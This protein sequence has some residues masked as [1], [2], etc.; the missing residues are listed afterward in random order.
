MGVFFKKV[1]DEFKSTNN[2]Q[3]MDRSR[4]YNPT[5]LEYKNFSLN[6]ITFPLSFEPSIVKFDFINKLSEER[7]ELI[8]SSIDL[9]FQFGCPFSTSVNYENFYSWRDRSFQV[10]L[11]ASEDRELSLH[12]YQDLTFF[13]INFLSNAAKKNTQRLNHYFDHESIECLLM[14]QE[15]IEKF[16][17]TCEEQIVPDK[18]KALLVCTPETKVDEVQNGA[19]KNSAELISL[20]PAGIKTSTFNF[21]ISPRE[22][23]YYWNE[24]AP[25]QFR[26]GRHGGF[27]LQYWMESGRILHS[28]TD[29]ELQ[30]NKIVKRNS[31]HS[32][33]QAQTPFS[34][35]FSKEKN[36]NISPYVKESVKKFQ[37]LESFFQ[38]K[39]PV[40]L[41]EGDELEA[42][43]ISYPI[44]TIQ[45]LKLESFLPLFQVELEKETPSS[46]ASPAKILSELESDSDFESDQSQGISVVTLTPTYHLAPELYIGNDF[47]FNPKSHQ[48]SIHGLYPSLSQINSEA[49]LHN[50]KFYEYQSSHQSL[51]EFYLNN[52]TSHPIETQE[53]GASLLKFLQENELRSFF[54]WSRIKPI[55]LEVEC[56]QL[57]LDH[58][59]YRFC[60]QLHEKLEDSTK[61]NSK[62]HVE[63]FL[64][65]WNEILAGFNEGLNAFLSPEYKNHLGGRSA[66][67][68][69]FILKFLR[70]SGIFI[71][72]FY[73]L[74]Q[75]VHATDKSQNPQ[76]L[77]HAT[78]KE[79]KKYFDE[80]LSEKLLLLLPSQKE[81]VLL[82]KDSFFSRE[83]MKLLRE[84]IVSIDAHL[85]PN[86][87]K[88]LFNRD[89]VFL[90]KG[91]VFYQ[92]KIIY[93]LLNHIITTSSGDIFKSSKNKYFPLPQMHSLEKSPGT[94]FLKPLTVGIY[95]SARNPDPNK[96]SKIFENLSSWSSH[97]LKLE[98]EKWNISARSMMSLF[99]SM[100]SSAN[101]L[102]VPV[103]LRFQGAPL[104]EVNSDN[105]HI[106]FSLTNAPDQQNYSPTRVKENHQHANGPIRWFD[107]HPQYFLNGKLISGDRAR[108]LLNE[109]VVE[110]EGRYYIID[111]RK[112][113]THKALTL[114]WN[115]L[116]QKKSLSTTRASGAIISGEK[117]QRHHVLEL[118]ALRKL[119]I[120]FQGPPEWDTLC[121]YFDDLSNPHQNISL[122][123]PL[124]TILKPYQKNGIQWLWDLYHLKLGGVLADDMGLGKT[125]QTLAFLQELKLKKKPH[126]TL[127]IVP[128]SL[129]YNWKAESEKFS[130][131]LKVEIF[132]PSQN[133]NKNYDILVCTYGL[134]PLHKEKLNNE[135]FNIIIFDEAQNLKNRST[136]RYSSALALS[137]DFKVALTGTPLENHLGNLYALF[138]CVAPGVLGSY[139]DFSKAYIGQ[140]P[141]VIMNLDFLKAQLKPLLLR[142]TK[143]QLLTELPEKTEIQIKI[144]FSSKQKTL[145]KKTA[146]TYSEQIA[147]LVAKKGENQVQL[148]MLSALLRLRQICSD[149]NG[150]PNT[151]FKETP[152]KLEYLIEHLKEIIEGGHSAI[153]FTQFL[154]TFERIKILA[155]ENLIPIYDM[156]GADSRTARIST[157]KQFESHPTGAILLM[158]LKT[159]GVGLN[160]TKANYVFHIDPW[161]NPAVENQATDRV[162]RIGQT[163]ATT[164][165]RLIMRE[166]VEEKVEILKQRKGQL[167]DSLFNE[168]YFSNESGSYG[169]SEG[170]F[171]YSNISSI[172]KSDFDSLLS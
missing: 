69:P 85:Q 99:K 71:Y 158:T 101:T 47:L 172:S 19:L 125:I 137:A 17:S 146:L 144:D 82:T 77:F 157:L 72:I 129:I 155:Q 9:I 87:V 29:R 57:D 10:Y 62:I 27:T 111:K 32:Q 54:D 96:M 109:Y 4:S 30:I 167:F 152:P 33:L 25:N 122:S 133:I 83:L 142:R 76:L 2:I 123:E 1:I 58:T 165:Y 18:I 106:Q 28:L 98:Q 166:S 134:L 14:A 117:T 110:H 26:T 136:E 131:N 148:H 78:D 15:K 154:S 68:R 49:P 46:Q 22:S 40:L 100:D 104:E 108:A 7:F 42:S 93:Q 91:L 86:I 23:S 79:F 21:V 156:C 118:L 97:T 124:N 16:Y 89:Q 64:P 115:K 6:A 60:F 160:L 74:L 39:I 159:G 43:R 38:A 130:P 35:I 92:S 113:P 150:L 5:K 63:S 37:L 151:Q 128:V 119:G 3:F 105:F 139:A 24:H 138:S 45:Y 56:L 36:K 161:W 20:Q 94:H 12:L 140:D 135:M 170:T 8:F 67:I 73:T 80:Q 141:F 90:T 95:Q 34:S 66:R 163:R 162:H 127:V 88:P 121:Q 59:S 51:I 171:N 168:D 11:C 126:K 61:S 103:E 107:L 102:P 53:Q 31:P 55:P 114:F 112:L 143:E 81:S 50:S 52:K 84:F 13:L 120:P 149:P 169:K 147:E 44:K 132:D 116:T 164:V 153:V 65:I 75:K 70:H 145:Y 48:L 41:T